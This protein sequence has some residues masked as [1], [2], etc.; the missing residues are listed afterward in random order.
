MH[1]NIHQSSNEYIAVHTKGYAIN[2]LSVSSKNIYQTGKGQM[3]KP[4]VT[5]YR[6]AVGGPGGQ[7][8]RTAGARTRSRQQAR[9]QTTLTPWRSPF[10]RPAGAACCA[11]PARQRTACCPVQCPAPSC[12]GNG[13][14]R[15]SSATLRMPAP[16][17]DMCE[18]ASFTS[19]FVFIFFP[20]WVTLS[21]TR[22][23]AAH[24]CDVCDGA[25]FF[26]TML[27]MRWMAAHCSDVCE[28]GFF[29]GRIRDHVS[30]AL[31]GG[32]LR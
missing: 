7:T 12:R 1:A 25:F 31:D 23:M 15:P 20:F 8:R 24:C 13:P 9:C 16:G 27:A 17:G 21:A 14:L 22:W 30:N 19:K 28:R 29:W 4:R 18:R 5:G 6:E 10:C 32:A 11:L 2:I 26:V 3:P